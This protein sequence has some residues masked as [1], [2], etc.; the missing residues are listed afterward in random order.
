MAR[1]SFALWTENGALNVLRLPLEEARTIAVT[2]LV[3]V[4][5]YLLA[6]EARATDAPSR[7]PP[8]APSC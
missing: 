4:G 1:P 3:R 5:L 2:V 8:S 6:L 7:C